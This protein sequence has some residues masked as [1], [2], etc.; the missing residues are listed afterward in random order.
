M[1]KPSIC[2]SK[3][4]PSSLWPSMDISRRFTVVRL[5][6]IVAR[7]FVVASVR[8]SLSRAKKSL[9]RSVF[10]CS[11]RPVLG[12]T[13]LHE[14]TELIIESITQ[15]S[16]VGR[17]ANVSNLTKNVLVA[18]PVISRPAANLAG[19]LGIF[20]TRSRAHFNRSPPVLRKQRLKS[21]DCIS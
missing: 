2:L 19:W 13:L 5:L 21:C 16:D 8:S 3:V 20:D 6:C 11:H 10:P 14:A 7:S 17:P 12:W 9:S 1:S 4:I 18:Q 15:A